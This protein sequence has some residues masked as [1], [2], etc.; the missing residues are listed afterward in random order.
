[1]IRPWG[2]I[3]LSKQHLICSRRPPE[4]HSLPKD[5][6]NAVKQLND[7]EL[8]LLITA[9]LEEVKRR[10]RTPPSNQTVERA[11]SIRQILP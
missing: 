4:S 10:G 2:V 8:D 5:L 11:S 6:A 3:A 9:C 7:R 1:M